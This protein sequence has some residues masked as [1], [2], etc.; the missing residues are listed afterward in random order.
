MSSN[1]EHEAAIPCRTIVIGKADVQSFAHID[2]LPDDAW[3]RIEAVL[4][5]VPVSRSTWDRG[6]RRGEFPPP[7]RLTPHIHVWRVSDVRHVLAGN[8][9]FRRQDTSCGAGSDDG[10]SL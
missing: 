2:M 4:A 6:V 10:H 9:R 5:F 7:F 8:L 3:L 1:D